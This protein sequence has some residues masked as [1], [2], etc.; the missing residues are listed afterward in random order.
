[1]QL[2][3]QSILSGLVLL[4]VAVLLGAFGA[5]ALSDLLIKN[6]RLSVYET[7]SQYHFYHGLALILF[8]MLNHIYKELRF[9][10]AIYLALLIGILIFSGSLYCLAIFNLSWLGAIAPIGGVLLLCGWFLLIYSIYLQ[11]YDD[12]LHEHIA[13]DEKLI[14]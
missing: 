7:A 3:K 6:N 14:K 12:D 4:F 11:P 5:H 10:G 8:G 13:V 9:Q 2:S 1:M